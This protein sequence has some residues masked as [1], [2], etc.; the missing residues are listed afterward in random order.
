MF[1]AIIQFKLFYRLRKTSLHQ[2]NL[3]RTVKPPIVPKVFI[4]ILRIVLQSTVSE[5]VLMY[6]AL[7]LVMMIFALVP[8]P[9]AITRAPPVASQK[10]NHS[11]HA[12]K[13]RRTVAYHMA[14]AQLLLHMDSNFDKNQ[15]VFVKTE[16]IVHDRFPRF[17]EN[18][19]VTIQKF[20]I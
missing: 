5:T 16:E 12:H 13:R 9:Q 1:G 10:W 11:Y 3:S 17:I 4:F 2:F 18:W 19:P 14:F 7:T 8:Q 6:Q 15:S 20:K